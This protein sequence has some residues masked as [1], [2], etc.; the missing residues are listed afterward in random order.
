[1]F[2]LALLAFAL[3]GLARLIGLAATWLPAAAW[4]WRV[5]RVVRAGDAGRGTAPAVLW[6][7]SATTWAHERAA[8]LP[9][10]C[11]RLGRVEAFLFL[12]CAFALLALSKRVAGVPELRLVGRERR[13]VVDAAPRGDCARCVFGRE[14]RPISHRGAA[15]LP[16]GVVCRTDGRPDRCLSTT[17][18]P[19]IAICR[20][21]Q[22]SPRLGRRVGRV[23]KAGSN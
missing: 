6:R 4:R 12:P 9:W 7:A 13:P 16:S 2:G 20:R 22:A 18:S 5:W 1:M 15:T 10:R 3:F 23:G 21:S 19:C 14:A 11:D 8:G 17:A